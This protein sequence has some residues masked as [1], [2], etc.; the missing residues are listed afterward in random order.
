M[1]DYYTILG[2]ECDCTFQTLKKAYYRKVK[3]CH[4]DL[5]NNSLLKTEEFKQLV[6]AF[7]ILSDPEKRQLY[8]TRLKSADYNSS[9]RNEVIVVTSS[10]MDSPADDILEELIS[11][12]I[13]P[14]DT[15]LATLMLDIVRTEVF[16][17]F[18]EGKNYFF[19]K[20]YQAAAIFMERA[21]TMSPGNIIYRTYFARTLVIARQY[22]KAKAQYRAALKLGRRRVPKQ[23]MRRVKSELEMVRQRHHPLAYRLATLFNVSRHE[24]SIPYDEELINATNRS[25]K[26]LLEQQQTADKE[27]KMLK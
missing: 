15:S 27:R 1:S 13:I 3:S 7:D 4:P 18:R 16:I 11:G 8:D 9:G 14:V 12:N 23:R 25:M 2:V 26:R 17:T 21:V 6:G 20:R 5:F 10:I 22:R 24:P 19:Q